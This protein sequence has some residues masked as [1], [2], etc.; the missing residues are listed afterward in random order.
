MQNEQELGAEQTGA[1][2]V[3]PATTEPTPAEPA[4]EEEPV[5]IVDA[6]TDFARGA[7]EDPSI[8]I[9]YLVEAGIVV[10]K[11]IAIFIVAR[12][13]AKTLKRLVVRGLV[14]AKLD[15][16]IAKF[17]GNIVAWAV[18][19]VAIMAILESFN[20]RTTGLA[21]VIAGASLAIGLA[22]QGSLGNLASGIMLMVFRPFK[23]GD[24]ISVNGVTAKVEEVELFS[25]IL[26][27][28]DNRRIFIPNGAIFGN[29]LENISFHK[30]RRVDVNVGTVYSADLDETREVLMRAASGVHGRLPDKDAVVFLSE[31]GDSSINWSVRVWVDAADFWAVKERLTRDVKVALDNAGIGIPFPQ[32]DVHIDGAVARD[33]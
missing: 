32:M 25:T 27:T 23:V 11:V 18:M 12:I 33:A 13:I 14:R 29:T 15:Q 30:T 2:Q 28:F 8:L 22:F 19:I 4:V 3:D 6:T 20:V 10:L 5:G 7:I 31:L 1:E 17:F 26:D 21:A 24:V 16:T 9:P